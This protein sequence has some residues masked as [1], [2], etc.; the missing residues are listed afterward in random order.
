[1]M[2]AGTKVLIDGKDK[3]EVVKALKNG[4][5]KVQF[6]VQTLGMLKP[7]LWTDTVR[8]ERMVAR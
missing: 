6:W 4:K 7:E 2:E 5:V 8:A 3:A 1:M